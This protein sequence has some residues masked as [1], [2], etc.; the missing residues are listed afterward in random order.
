MASSARLTPSPVHPSTEPESETLMMGNPPEDGRNMDLSHKLS[1]RELTLLYEEVLY[2]ILHRVGQVEQNHVTDSDELYEY[3][4]KAFS[5]DPGQHQII[6]QRVKELERPIFCLKATVKQAR[7]ILG[8]DVSGLSDPYCLLGI[9]RK[10]QGSSDHGSHENKRRS[11][12]VV[13]NLLPEDQTHRTQVIHQTLNPVWDET[14]ILEFDD[15]ENAEFQLDMWDFDAVEPVRHKL[16]E[17]SDLRGLKRII[18]DARKNKGQDD[19]L[20]NVVIHLQDLHCREDRWYRL[21][22]RT[23]TYPNRGHCH[24]QFFLIHKKRATSASKTQASYKVHR[25]LLQQ[26]VSYE[27]LQY[28]AGSTSWDGELSKHACT[29]LYLHATQKDIS[30][31]HQDL[32]HWLAYS[33]LYQFLEFNSSCLLHQITSIEYQWI[34]GRLR[35]EQ[36]AELADSFRSLLNYGI[37]LLQRFRIVFPLSSPKS[38]QRLQSLLR[39]LVQMCKMKAFK[40]LCTPTPDLEKMVMEA[41]KI[42]TAEWFYMKKQHLKPMVKTMEECGKALVCLLLEVNADLQEC[43]RTW[44]KYFISMRLDL[45][46]IA[47]LKMQ[48]LVSCYVQEQLSKIDSGMSQLTAESL[49]QLYLSM[50]DFYHMKDL[51]CS[52]DTPLALTGFHLWFKEAIPLWLQKT[53]TIALERTQRA[54]QVDQLTPLGELNKHSTS[55]VDLSTCYAQMV[56]TWQQLDWPDPE[57]AFMIMV[58]FVEDTCKIAQMYC[59]MIKAR[60]EELSSNQSDAGQA[61]NRL[62]VVVNNIEQLRMMILKLPKQLN[63]AFLEQ[64]TGPVITPEQIQHTLH[65]QLQASVSCLNNEIRGVVKTLAT[66]MDARIARHIQELSVC[67]DSDNPENCIT[68]LMRF[69]EYEFQYLNVNLVQENFNSLLE[70]LWNHTLDLLK[71][72]TKQQVGKLD[73]FRRFQ[74]ALQSLELCFH[75]EGC[76]LSKDALHTPAFIALEKELDLCSSTSRKLI[77]KYFSARI[78]QQEEATPEKYG[79]VTIKAFYRHSEQK[80]Y[81]EVLNAVNL[82]PL[83]S[84]GLSDPFIQ[85]TLEPRHEFPEI[86]IRTTECIKNNLH[87]LFD[88]AFEFLVPPE[89]CQQDGACLLLTVF[90]YDTLGA[91]DL[92]GEAFLPLCRVLGLNEPEESINPSRVPQIRLSLTHPGTAGNDILKLLGTRKGDK[93]AQAFVKLRKQRAKYSKELA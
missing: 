84:N 47:Y 10:N 59:Q 62:C 1:K 87:P 75:G 22:P 73:Y 40:E 93:E 55:I 26:V 15:V 23:D 13:K 16:E 83:D 21:E 78:Q 36:T 85:L 2:T 66:K 88:E 80:L 89:K 50:K 19:F 46:S 81:V 20:G 52:R 18:K 67:S 27:I 69:L 42:G 53:Y 33:K 74:F 5:I 51:V 4:Q 65:Q 14:F 9:E 3:V 54:I 7:N 17:L 39:V 90:D 28:Q 58:K 30:D 91:N 34:Q 71:N 49:F 68:P 44:N 64:N 60:A 79:A 31:F 76:G 12:G 82:L 32:A 8:K 48:E 6:L 24:L 38:T 61:A 37:S 29:I 86:A 41:L 92:E 43:H 11:K 70:L 25:Q 56:K 35:S 77:E 45:F 63:W 57:E 72:A